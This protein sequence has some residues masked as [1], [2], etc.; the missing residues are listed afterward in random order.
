MTIII[1]G[2]DSILS[3]VPKEMREKFPRLQKPLD[4]SECSLMLEQAVSALKDPDLGQS[5]TIFC[6][7]VRLIM[8]LQLS[9]ANANFGNEKISNQGSGIIT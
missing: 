1:G 9:V 3:Q 6:D 8:A 2:R 4:S 7:I 5:S